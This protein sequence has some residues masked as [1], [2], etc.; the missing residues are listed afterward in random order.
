[1]TTEIDPELDLPIDAPAPIPG[2]RP[3]VSVVMPAFNEALLLMDSLTTLYGYLESITDRYDWELV[4]VNDGSTDETGAIADAFALRRPEVRVLHH[5]VNFNLG[6]AL[7][8]AFNTCQGDYVVT[9]DSDLS[10]S[11]DHIEE[12]LAGLR[13]EYAKIALASPYMKGGSTSGIPPHR[14][15]LS[16]AANR[17]LSTMSGGS[18]ATLTGMVRAYDRVF[19]QSL[20]LK[21]MG[22]DINAEILYKAQVLGARV[23][24]VPAHLDWKSV[25]ERA[26]ERTSKMQLRT[27][28]THYLFSGF[29]FRPVLFFLIPGLLLL[30]VAIYMLSWIGWQTI[31][32]Y[33]EVTGNP[34]ARFSDAIGLTYDERPHAFVVGGVTLLLS[35]QL[36]SIGV[37]ASQSK[38]YFE[39]MFHLATTIYR[40]PR[41]R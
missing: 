32:H 12:L 33:G 17:F 21:A 35:V 4:I 25:T 29:M 16:R 28:T 30:I 9:I 11:P 39:E 14:R 22:T 10:Y 8:F 34:E 27:G 41:R 36:I 15:F 38:R 24:E 1:M 6:Q 7:R 2:D 23:T 19:L 18:I 20:D 40:D 31:V 5:P 3:S 13:A 37:L 26:P